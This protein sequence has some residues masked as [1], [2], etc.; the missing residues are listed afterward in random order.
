MLSQNSR[1][2]WATDLLPLGVL[3]SLLVSLL[4]AFPQ[5]LLSSCGVPGAALAVECVPHTD[6]AH[7][8]LPPEPLTP[9]VS[10]EREESWG[11]HFGC[12]DGLGQMEEE[13]CPSSAG[14]TE[15]G[16]G[17]EQ[18]QL[19]L[20]LLG[21]Q[22]RPFPPRNIPCIVRRA[23]FAES[24]TTLVFIV[25]RNYPVVH[26]ARTFPGRVGAVLG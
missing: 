17:K 2:S 11:R 12:W 24:T 16:K 8:G 13:K 5:C 4:P 26:H 22:E 20:V 9:P 7:V 23:V 19:W 10:Q 18:P 6:P 3:S 15:P 21:C 1:I 25:N 14:F